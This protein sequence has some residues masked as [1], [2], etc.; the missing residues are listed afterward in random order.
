MFSVA[1]ARQRASLE[2]AGGRADAVEKVASI[3]HRRTGQ[4]FGIAFPEQALEFPT[5]VQMA[6]G[7]IRMSS[8]SAV[9]TSGHCGSTRRNVSRACRRLA[10]ARSLKWP[11]HSSVASLPREMARGELSAT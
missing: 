7:Q 11:S 1:G 6:A 5:S 10:R 9:I 4:P 2:L 3:K 8:R